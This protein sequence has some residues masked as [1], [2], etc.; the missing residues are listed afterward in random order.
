MLCFMFQS[1]PVTGRQKR[2]KEVTPLP[3]EIVPLKG[4]VSNLSLFLI[5]FLCVDMTR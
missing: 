3:S 5:K 2:L 1:T 4:E